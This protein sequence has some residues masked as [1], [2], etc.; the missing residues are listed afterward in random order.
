MA[1]GPMPSCAGTSLTIALWLSLMTAWPT[2]LLHSV[3]ALLNQ[4]QYGWLAMSMFLSWK[5]SIHFMTL[6]IHAGIYLHTT[7]L[8]ADVCK[9]VFL[10][11]EFNYCKLAKCYV[12]DSHFV[13]LECKNISYAHTLDLEG[14]CCYWYYILCSIIYSTNVIQLC[15][16]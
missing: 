14:R 16:F 13:T 2:S 5:Y 3:V 12:T 9:W 8:P 7:K 15:L 10:D 4:P 11:K 1:W 6:G